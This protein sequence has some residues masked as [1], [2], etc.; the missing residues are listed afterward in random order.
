MPIRIHNV[1][2]GLAANSSSTHSLILLHPGHH[3]ATTTHE[4]FGWDFFTAADA[5]SKENYLGL[6]VYS[7]LYDVLDDEQRDRVIQELFPHLR[8]EQAYWKKDGK[9]VL[10]GGVD[11]QSAWDLPMA[12]DGGTIDAAFIEDFRTFLANERIAILGGNDNTTEHHPLLDAYP[13]LS[14]PLGTDR[15]TSK[16]LV[17]RKNGD[18]WTLFNRYTGAKMR[19]HFLEDGMPE[20]A[21]T[22]TDVPELIDIKIT[23]YCPFGCK[24]CYQSST[25]AGRHAS[26][27]SVQELAQWCG[28]MKV[29]EVAIGGG[30]P[31]LHPDFVRILEAFREQHVLPNFTTRN[32]AWMKGP[33]AQRISNAMGSLAFSVE[34]GADVKRLCDAIN[35]VNLDFER[36]HVSVQYVVGSGGDLSGI[37]DAAAEANFRVTLLGFKSV[38]FGAHYE[39]D[40]E[41]WVTP[42]Q[43]FFAAS[44]ATKL[45][46]STRRYVDLAIDTKIIQ[47]DFEKLREELRVRP[48][49][50]SPYEGKFSMYI[51]AVDR[52]IGPSSY[53]EPHEYA[54]LTD[55][56]TLLKTFNTW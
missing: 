42:V 54:P 26:L 24:Y 6:C 11:H 32:L 51:D 4:D 16:D 44:I 28:A 47:T 48:V 21:P 19:M 38:G 45:G 50:L 56:D 30:E 52:K 35:G 12:W 18:M 20:C 5:T 31:T 23:D 39:K 15:R 36:R 8:F 17:A 33:D 27:E 1:R 13:E 22:R 40:A 2:L 9:P 37:L 34:T 46:G 14:V 3:V 43:E 7:A 10:H 41:N 49:L 55:R 53:C 25:T 29:F